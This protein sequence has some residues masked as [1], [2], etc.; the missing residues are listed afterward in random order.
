M[1]RRKLIKNATLVSDDRSMRGAL[2]IEDEHIERIIPEGESL[3]GVLADAVVDAEGGYLLPGVIDEHVH[4]RDPGLTH[5]ADFESESR[6]AAA[7]GVTTVID[8]PNVVPQTTTL[9]ALR[10]KFDIAAAKSRVNYSFFFGVTRENLDLIKRLNRRGVC[11][12]KV[13]MGSST[14][15]MLVDDEE[16]LDRLFA[17]TSRAR[18]PLMAHCEDTNTINR[19]MA[20]CQ[21][22]HGKDPDVHFHAEIRSREAC[23]AST[24]RA[25]ELAHRHEARLHVA[26]VSTADELALFSPDDHLVTAE[27][28]VP[29][30]IFSDEDYARLGARIK[31]NPSIKTAADREALRRALNDGTIT[32]VATDHA[33]HTLEEKV[34]GAARALSGMPMVQF[35]LV[36]MLEL[37]DKGVLSIER[38]VELM[39]HAPARLFGIESRGFL[40]EG[41]KADLVLLHHNS[42]WTLTPNRILS[43]CNWSPLEGRTFH[44]RVAKTYCNGYLICN[45]GHITDDT[46]RGQP[47]TFDR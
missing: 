10:E 4:F 9:E 25:I 46:F 12:L 17:A 34:G 41:Y 30:L 33:P 7:G 35:S 40:R 26:H 37:V 28:C 5:K 16:S 13:F 15:N 20:A 8:M 38:L 36:A 47:V 1:Y 44:W 43:R 14:G 6:A 31:C 32:T 23:L 24:R 21:L 29:H 45:R 22:A 27:A 18:L 39:C 11:G 3:K 19:N 2:L 42:P